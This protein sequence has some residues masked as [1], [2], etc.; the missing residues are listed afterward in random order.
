MSLQDAC[1]IFFSELPSQLCGKQNG[2]WIH[3]SW[4]EEGLYNM[5]LYHW[6]NPI[7]AYTTD[8]VYTLQF[9]DP[10]I[11]KTFLPSI[12]EECGNKRTTCLANSWAVQLPVQLL[13][14]M[15]QSVLE[16]A[17]YTWVNLVP[18]PSISNFSKSGWLVS[19]CSYSL[20]SQ[21]VGRKL[22]VLFFREQINIE[23]QLEA[24]PQILWILVRCS[25]HSP[26]GPATE[27]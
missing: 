24:K 20:L 14:K 21:L 2:V 19:L 3:D 18:L 1:I 22:V 6:D 4:I 5:Q 9:F 16:L 23:I 11:T 26:A 13:C 12:L 25:Y 10:C 17:T 27:K 8:S 15:V 7:P